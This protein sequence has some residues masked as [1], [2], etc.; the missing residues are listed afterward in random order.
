[1]A[2]AKGT[3]VSVASSRAEIERMLHRYGIS[4]FQSGW[5]GD[6]AAILFEK[7]GRRVRFELRLPAASEFLKTPENRTRS[8]DDAKRAQAAEHRRLW[9]ALCLVIKAKLESVESGIENFE[10]AF[11]ANVVL[12][13][14][15]KTFGE[16]AAPKIAAA[17]DQGAKMPPMLGSGT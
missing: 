1:M 14:D 10:E 15:G 4:G 12:P 13:G 3:V 17:Y 5:D 16:W 8:A 7:S 9:R 11:L 6:R 2:F